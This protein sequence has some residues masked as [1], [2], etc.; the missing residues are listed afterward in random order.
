MAEARPIGAHHHLFQWDQ[1]MAGGGGDE[2]LCLL[3]HPAL[4]YARL[5]INVGNVGE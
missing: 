1:L 5:G 3:H 4:T 2:L